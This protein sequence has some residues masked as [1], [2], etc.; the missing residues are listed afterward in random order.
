[1]ARPSNKLSID[2]AI[3]MATAD[4]SCLGSVDPEC[5]SNTDY[6]SQIRRNTAGQY[7]GW[8]LGIMDRTPGSRHSRSRIARSASKSDPMVFLGRVVN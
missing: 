4:L 5:R 1:M 6:L 3:R 8:V 7:L 2:I